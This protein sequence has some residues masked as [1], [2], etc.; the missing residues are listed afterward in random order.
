M[1]SSR[2]HDCILV[3]GGTGSIGSPLVKRLLD[4]TAATIRI[5]SRNDSSHHEFDTV[6]SPEHRKRIRFILGDVRNF[7]TVKRAVYGCTLVFHC[8]AAKHVN[9]SGYNAMEVASVNVFGTDN[10]LTALH[11][12][13]GDPVM[14]FLSTDKAAN[15]SNA[16]GASKTLAERMVIDCIWARVIRRVTRFG[17]VWLSRGSIAPTLI[18][19]IVKKRIIQLTDLDATRFIMTIDRAVDSLMEAGFG[20]APVVKPKDPYL[21]VPDMKSATVG[22]MFGWILKLFEGTTLEETIGSQVIG[23]QPGEKKH[24]CI[25]ADHE[26]R[27]V[28]AHTGGYVYVGRDVQNGINTSRILCNSSD[29]VVDDSQ[30]PNIIPQG[31]RNK[32]LMEYGK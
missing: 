29:A 22:Q 8:A 5:L 17:N 6:L 30:F 10:V 7:R 24:E 1:S 18:N 2:Q 12:E 14:V 28:F 11:E 26:L 16:M 9:R 25:L 19:Q 32:I 4:C 20:E 27:D 3:T 23:L 21:I 13:P 15:P 31:L